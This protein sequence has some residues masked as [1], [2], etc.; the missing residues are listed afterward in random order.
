IAHYLPAPNDIKQSLIENMELS[1]INRIRM[2]FPQEKVADPQLLS[3]MMLDLEQFHIK[4]T[5]GNDLSEV[6]RSYRILVEASAYMLQKIDPE[7][8]PDSYAKV[9]LLYHDAQCVRNRPDQALLYAKIAYMV[10]LSVEEIEPG[11]TKEQRDN[12]KI[13]AIRCEA[14]AYHNMGLDKLVPDILLQ[15]C[16]AM[17]AY[18]NLASYWEPL[19]LRDLINSL[20]LLPRYSIREVNKI[21][22]HIESVCE[23]NNDPFTLLLVRESW[24]RSQIKRGKIKFAQCL[25]QEEVNRLPYLPYVGALHKALLFK[26]GA[27]LA[28]RQND[29]DAWKIY[30]TKAVTLMQRAGLNHQLD[31]VKQTY[32]EALIPIF[33]HLEAGQDSGIT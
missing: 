31:L 16:C 7:K 28:W 3:T 1:R 12:L 21:A 13:N 19:V 24:L 11:Y 10:L 6:Q 20:V 32:G 2:Q 22:K 4:A 17:S 18:R 27:E 26:S 14:V 33:T 9:C 8:H 25:F 5:F 30:I 23:R 15:K 29:L